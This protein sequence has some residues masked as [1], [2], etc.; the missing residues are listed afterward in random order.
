MKLR[1]DWMT[2]MTV[3]EEKSFHESASNG[4]KRRVEVKEAL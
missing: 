2:E 1:E 4:T 3:E